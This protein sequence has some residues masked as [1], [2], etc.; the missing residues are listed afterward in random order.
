M[1]N[2]RTKKLSYTIKEIDRYKISLYQWLIV[3][4]MVIVSTPLLLTRGPFFLYC[5]CGILGIWMILVILKLIST[6]KAKVLFSIDNEGL[7]IND[8][9]IIKSFSWSSLQYINL[10]LS[11]LTDGRW[12]TCLHVKTRTEAEI[13]LPISIYIFS[14]Y[15]TSKQIENIVLEYTGC[16]DKFYCSIPPLWK[17]IVGIRQ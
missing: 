8:K 12:E 6:D 4:L 13:C 7:I 9:G 3:F 14:L 16:P 5:M 1:R 2:T 11:Q 10:K 17:R 15:P